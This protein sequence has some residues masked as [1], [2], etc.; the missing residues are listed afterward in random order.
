MNTLKLAPTNP[1][2]KKRDHCYYC[3]IYSIRIEYDHFPIPQEAG[4]T[5]TV[6]ACINC[7]DL[8]DRIPLGDWDPDDSIGGVAE[9]IQKG[10]I[11]TTK[12][13]PPYQC[14]DYQPQWTQLSRKA[15]IVYAKMRRIAE[16]AKAKATPTS[17]ESSPA[18]PPPFA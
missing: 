13:D 3:D 7:H 14:H 6:P 12:E 5:E 1:K 2:G 17:P 10:L 11:E 8:K 18:P 9:L 15:R 4:G 16:V